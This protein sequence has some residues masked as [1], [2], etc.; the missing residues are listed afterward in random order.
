MSVEFYG[1]LLKRERG[2]ER[3]NLDA[4]CWCSPLVFIY[5]ICIYCRCSDSSVCVCIEYSSFMVLAVLSRDGFPSS[6]ATAS[7]VNCC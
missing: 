6:H 3:E 1:I 4:G 7:F 2:R 5:G